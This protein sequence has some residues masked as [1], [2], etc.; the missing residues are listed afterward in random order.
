MKLK[1]PIQCIICDRVIE[2]IT[3]DKSSLLLVCCAC[4]SSGVGKPAGPAI[5]T[6]RTGKKE[7]CDY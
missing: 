4:K 7:G 1:N 6:S 2:E 3:K 5:W